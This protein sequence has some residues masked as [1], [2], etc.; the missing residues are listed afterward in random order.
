M[1]KRTVRKI[2]AS[3]KLLGESRR[4]IFKANVIVVEEY[5]EFFYMAVEFFLGDEFRL[6]R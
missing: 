3:A 1:H 2:A 5:E 6:W 4:H